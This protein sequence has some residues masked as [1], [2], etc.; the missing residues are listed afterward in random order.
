[1]DRPIFTIATVLCGLT[2]SAQPQPTIKTNVP[3]V[4]VP[5]TVTDRKGT[6]IDGLGVDDFVVTDDGVKRSVRM[7]TSDTVLAP[8]SVVVAV[9]CSDISAAALAKI[10]RVG[11]MIQ[12]LIAGER[13]SA[14]VIAFDDEVRVFQ[15]FTS[16]ASKIRAAFQK[17]HGRTIGVG[18]MLD[19]VAQGSMM[20]ETRPPNHRRILIVLSESR[21]R[22][23]K[24]K[25]EQA[26]E[27]I[28]RANVIVYPA[29]YSA[30]LTP[31]TAKP[32]DNPTTGGDL[33]TGLKDLMRLG[34][35][36]TADALAG[37][38]GGQHLA[39]GT[40]HGLEAALTRAGEQ[41][42]GQYLLSFAPGESDNHDFH[43]LEVALPSRPD[44]IIRARPGYWPGQ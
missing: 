14:A 43:R 40:L 27:M 44:A 35:T 5:V 8:V 20:L 3:L 31:W 6:L 24:T 1:V 9:Q 17:I 26:I 42:H 41:I 11:G 33:M 19:A 2:V 39:F 15:D 37:A 36:N 7:D 4:L 32:Q 29:T 10:N 22:G 21:D 16:D 38:S 34:K 12:P 23:S 13:G 30:Y 28:G 25:L 18:K